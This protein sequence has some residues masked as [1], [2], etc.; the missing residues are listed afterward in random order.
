VQTNIP[1]NT[2]LSQDVVLGQPTGEEA[3]AEPPY[4]VEWANAF[5]IFSPV[6][7]ED[8]GQA[9]TFAKKTSRQYAKSMQKG[10]TVD[11]AQGATVLR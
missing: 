3:S 11:I 5:N 8:L 9:E 10:Q 7:F 6:E 4:K 1:S 2:V